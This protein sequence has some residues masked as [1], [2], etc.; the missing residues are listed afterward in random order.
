MSDIKW[1][2][3]NEN[4]QQKKTAWI[5]SYNKTDLVK[6]CEKF[7]IQ[8]EDNTTLDQL[9][10]LVREFVKSKETN[11]S[12]NIQE[13]IKMATYYGDIESFQKGKSWSSFAS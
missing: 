11:T 3:V 10:H 2:E 6:I 7:E 12:E 8:T 5:Q 1:D 4:V 9:R 13:V